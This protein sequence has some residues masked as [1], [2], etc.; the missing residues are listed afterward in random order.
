MVDTD[1]IGSKRLHR[2]GIELA[3]VCIEQGIR[4]SALICNAWYS[5]PGSHV[6]AIISTFEEKLLAISE[7]LFTLDRDGG[8]GQGSARKTCYQCSSK[9]RRKHDDACDI[10]IGLRS[11]RVEQDPKSQ[12][13]AEC[14]AKSKKQKRRAILKYS[15]N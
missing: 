12:L 5:Q 1:R 2:L 11:G 4:W 13:P 10:C 7:E 8:N 9:K 15:R 6:G 3:L 14:G